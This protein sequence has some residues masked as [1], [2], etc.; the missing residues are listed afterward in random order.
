MGKSIGI[1]SLKGGV[2]KTS[3]VVG[4]GAALAQFGKKVL[5]VDGNFSSPNIG[6]HLKMLDPEVTIH[7][8]LSRNSNFQDSIHVYEDLFHFIPAN[9]FNEKEINPLNLRNRL[10]DVKREYDIILIDSSPAL[11]DETLAAMLA[12]DE[13]FAVTTPDYTTLATTIKAIKEAKSRGTPIKGLVLNKV[14]NKKF[15]L[16]TKNIEDTA[17]LPIMAV[18]PYDVNIL[19][20]QANFIPSVV[21]NPGSDA[22]REFKKFAAVLVGK[23]YTPFTLRDLF[24]THS[25]KSQ[26]INRE[27]YYKS[28]FD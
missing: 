4:L 9:L 24:R 3:V 25:P 19:R 17:E 20:A 10:K 26:D 13:L 23:R 22:S 12:S 2:G 8:V 7:D 6:L 16:S 21:Y 11:N 18:I 5:L 15:E 1:I 14:H 28:I 27:I